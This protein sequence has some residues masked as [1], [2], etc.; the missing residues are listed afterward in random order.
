ML[1]MTKNENDLERKAYIF[2]T[3]GLFT[4]VDPELYESL[5]RYKWY[6]RM[7]SSRWYAVRYVRKGKKLYI[8][9]MHRQIAKTQPGFVCHH[10]NGNSLDNRKKNLEN[11][12]RGLHDIVHWKS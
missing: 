3:H 9:R 7:S 6:A 2:L 12:R 8:I 4:I 5:S 10:K 1:V 11:M